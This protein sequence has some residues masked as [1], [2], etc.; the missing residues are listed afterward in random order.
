MFGKNQDP[1]IGKATQFPHQIRIG[2]GSPPLKKFR[3][4][5]DDLAKCEDVIQVSPSDVN[6]VLR[7]DGSVMYYEL[8]LPTEQAI[9]AN[10]Q[11]MS[12]RDVRWFEQLAKIKGLYAPTKIAETDVEGNDKMPKE[13]TINII[14]TAK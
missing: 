14:H 2:K 1:Q 13:I 7:P 8:K 4:L 5:L 10:L 6:P 11:R 9:A 3:Q 12:A